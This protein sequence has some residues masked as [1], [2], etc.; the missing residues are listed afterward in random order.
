MTTGEAIQELMTTY[1]AS[2]TTWLR[3]HGNDNGFDAWFTR[4]VRET[5][6]GPSDADREI[7]NRLPAIT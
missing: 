7:N 1:T 4:Q 3:E 6:R 2:R 5:F